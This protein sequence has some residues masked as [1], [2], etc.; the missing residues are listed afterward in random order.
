MSPAPCVE[1]IISQIP[2]VDRSSNNGPCTVSVE[3]TGSFQLFRQMFRDVF[4]AAQ[5]A[6]ADK[7]NVC[8]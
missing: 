8:H 4:G 6:A 7:S 1:L 3:K 2:E 5:G